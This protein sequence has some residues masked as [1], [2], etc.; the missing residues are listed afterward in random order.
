M[1]TA[2]YAGKPTLGIVALLIGIACVAPC[3]DLTKNVGVTVTLYD[4]HGVSFDSAKNHVL[5]V[6]LFR[7]HTHIHFKISNTTDQG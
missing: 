3:A 6:I 5:E 4:S 1:L 7:S 2:A